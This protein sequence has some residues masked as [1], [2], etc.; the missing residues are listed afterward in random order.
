M[1]KNFDPPPPQPLAPA[2]RLTPVLGV[3]K[4]FFKIF[5][6]PTY[7][8]KM[9]STTRRSLYAIYVWVRESPPAAAPPP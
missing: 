8:L 2:C 1:K 7:Y 9:I 6:T 4:I 5:F 3:Q